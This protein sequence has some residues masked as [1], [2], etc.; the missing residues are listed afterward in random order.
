[1]LLE[2]VMQVVGYP[3]IKERHLMYNLLIGSVGGYS[4][5]DHC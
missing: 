4:P 3:G 1:M 2:V 5:L